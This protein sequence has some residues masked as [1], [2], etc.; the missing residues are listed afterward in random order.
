M[1]TILFINMNLQ[2]FADAGT[3]VTGMN[4]GARS[5]GAVRMC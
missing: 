2:L 1:N 3:M 4:P 5:T